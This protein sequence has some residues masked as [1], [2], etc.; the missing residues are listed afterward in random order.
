MRSKSSWIL[1]LSAVAAGYYL[2]E[3]GGGGL[4]VGEGIFKR[5]SVAIAAGVPRPPVPLVASGAR[6]DGKRPVGSKVPGR[7]AESTVGASAEFHYLRA[8]NDARAQGDAPRFLAYA[9]AFC[10]RTVG[11]ESARGAG[12]ATA[13][14]LTQL[15]REAVVRAN[16]AARKGDPAAQL[17]ELSRA[18]L[19]ALSPA[20]RDEYRRILQQLSASEILSRRRS[21]D[22]HFH[23]VEPGESLGRIAARYNFP[24]G[25]IQAVNGLR[26]TVIRVGQVLKVP[27]GP[28]EAIAFKDDYRLLVLSGGKYLK[29]YAIGIGKEDSTPEGVFEIEEKS[30]NPTW[31]APDGVYPPGHPKNILGTRWF[32]FRDTE[33]HEGYGIHGTS[34]PGSI[35]KAESS[36]CIRLRNEDVEELFGFLPRGARVVIVP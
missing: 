18:Y 10:K 28:V 32:G 11:C 31:Y 22:A 25:G 35:G 14:V 7:S 26:S 3:T 27:Q 19:A 5:P 2:H 23:K 13:G 36:G 4:P 34:L 30:I 6:G 24:V 33:E 29:E 15:E 21:A 1:I 20:R 12:E 16:E 9:T 8:A 17:T